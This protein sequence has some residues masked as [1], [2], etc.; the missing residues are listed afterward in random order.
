[1]KDKPKPCAKCG[2]GT[3]RSDRIY[4]VTDYEKKNHYLC[5]MSCHFCGPVR[6][7]LALAE[8]AWNDLHKGGDDE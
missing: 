3:H 6:E 7:T 4:K 5:C 1:V 8:E 2:H